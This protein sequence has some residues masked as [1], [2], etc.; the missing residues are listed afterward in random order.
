MNNLDAVCVNVDDFCQIF[1]PTW[2]KYL[3]SS[4]IK[5]TEKQAFSPLR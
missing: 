4:G 2:E 3:I 5:Q 1:L